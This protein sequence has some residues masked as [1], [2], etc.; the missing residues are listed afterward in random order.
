MGKNYLMF[1]ADRG[2]NDPVMAILKSRIVNV[3]LEEC[4]PE[5][6]ASMYRVAIFCDFNVMSENGVIPCKTHSKWYETKE[7]AVALFKKVMMELGEDT[8]STLNTGGD[9]FDKQAP[10]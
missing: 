8:E 2:C 5:H 1:C 4:H 6:E 10:D 7:K 9:F 3:V